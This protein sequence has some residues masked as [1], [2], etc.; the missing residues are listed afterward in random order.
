MKDKKNNIKKLIKLL[1]FLLHEKSH[2]KLIEDALAEKRKD[3]DKI[4]DENII[5]NDIDTMIENIKS[6]E[7]DL[8]TVTDAIFTKILPSQNGRLDDIMY[9]KLKASGIFTEEELDKKFNEYRKIDEEKPRSKYERKKFTYLKEDPKADIVPR[10]IGNTKT[11][12]QTK[13]EPEYITPKESEFR[14]RERLLQKANEEIKAKQASQTLLQQAAETER[15]EGI[16]KAKTASKSLIQS[17]ITKQMIKEQAE[18]SKQKAAEEIQRKK[19]EAEIL[20]IKQEK[21]QQEEAEIKRIKEIEAQEKL[22]E[23]Q[24]EKNLKQIAKYLVSKNVQNDIIN[25]QTKIN[26]AKQKELMKKLNSEIKEKT[27]QREHDN[28]KIE[29]YIYRKRDKKEQ[30]TNS[31]GE[32]N[33]TKIIKSQRRTRKKK[34]TPKIEEKPEIPTVEEKPIDPPKP[35]PETEEKPNDPPVEEIPQITKFKPRKRNKRT[36][37]KVEGPITTVEPKKP[38]V[39]VLLPPYK[40]LIANI[41]DKNKAVEFIDNIEKTGVDL[42]QQKVIGVKGYKPQFR[43][44]IRI[45]VNDLIETYGITKRDLPDDF[46]NPEFLNDIIDKI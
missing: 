17:V 37:I 36:L 19:K 15:Q 45:I 41:D 42:P 25:D 20:E 39:E 29:D 5:L 32:T 1:L 34:E 9:T 22:K 40:K 35:E 27:E 7:L 38:K 31:K 33:R 14:K 28:S 16:K 24:E 26:K 3:K 2:R 6:G 4:T 18:A 12:T 8:K 23:K 13:S 46:T 10:K 43:E 30:K 21:Q 44:Q 11:L